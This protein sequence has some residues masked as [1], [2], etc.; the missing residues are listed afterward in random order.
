[1]ARQDYRSPDRKLIA[2]V[3]DVNEAHESRVEIHTSR[4]K[5][6]LA[7]DYS[8]ND[9]EHGE[10][11]LKAAWT[12]DGEFFVFSMQNTGGHSPMG[13]PTSFYSRKQNLLFNLEDAVGYITESDF[14]WEAPNWIIT[15]R[16]VPSGEGE[17]EPVRVA[18][19]EVQK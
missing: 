12:P 10:S 9:M 1:M 8:S 7:Q 19:S 16:L 4:G 3:I 18:L 13:R 2:T 6:L 14:K 17:S 11:V 15:K 5:L